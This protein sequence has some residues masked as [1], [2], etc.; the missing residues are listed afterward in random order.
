MRPEAIHRREIDP[1]QILSA[2]E[3]TGADPGLCGSEHGR[4]VKAAEGRGIIGGRAP[5]TRLTLVLE[6]PWCRSPT[7]SPP[8]TR[9]PTPAP[10]RDRATPLPT[11]CCSRCWPSPRGPPPA[12]AP[13]C[14]SPGVA[15]A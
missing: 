2:E 15:S 5:L 12:A 7:R 4:L 14:P 11:S 10:P 1:E 6:P 3:Q 13:W 8:W 9:S